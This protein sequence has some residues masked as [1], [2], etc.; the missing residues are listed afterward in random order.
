MSEATWAEGV[1][2]GEFKNPG[3]RKKKKCDKPRPRPRG[4]RVGVHKK[5]MAKRSQ[6][7]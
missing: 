1:R 6:N 2:I 7:K 5:R 4:L 3:T